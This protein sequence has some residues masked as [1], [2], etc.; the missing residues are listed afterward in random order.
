MLKAMHPDGYKDSNKF[1]KKFDAFSTD[2]NLYIDD[3]LK[4]KTTFINFWFEG[5]LPCIAEFPALNDLYDRYKTNSQFQFL[6]FTFESKETALRISEKYELKYPVIHIEREDIH[7]LIFN[8]GFPTS[9]IT[10]KLGK[11]RFIICGGFQEK[12][13]AKERIDSIYIKEIERVLN[14]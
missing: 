7:R 5:C 14:D 13:K 6:S 9:M 8:L 11:I 2:G 10:D 1:F 4:S 3:S 12:E